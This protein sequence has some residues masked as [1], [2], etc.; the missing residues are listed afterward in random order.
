MRRPILTLERETGPEI[1]FLDL[2]G[3]GRPLLQ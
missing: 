2:S 1:A 3:A